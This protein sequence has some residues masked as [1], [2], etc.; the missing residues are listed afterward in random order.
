MI[1][2]PIDQ[3]VLVLFAGLLLAAAAEDVRRLII[4]NRYCLAIALLFPAQVLAATAPVDW[5]GALVLASVTLAAGIA[6]FALNLTGGGDVKLFAAAALWVGP[7]LFRNFLLVTTLTG[8][9]IAL[10]MLTQRRLTRAAAVAKGPAREAP[11]AVD[12]GQRAMPYGLA[13]AAGG[14]HVAVT[15]FLKG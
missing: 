3:V 14:I 8:A 7:G 10:A 2:H 6:L 5:L 1:T 11:P 4:P 12:P 9:G 13:I 15:L